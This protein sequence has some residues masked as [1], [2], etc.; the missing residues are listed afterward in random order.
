VEFL[1]GIACEWEIALEATYGWEWLARLLEDERLSGVAP[2]GL[3]VGDDREPLEAQR[4]RLG[5][6]RLPLGH[7]GDDAER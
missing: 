2:G 7:G 5:L 1:R 4:L 6:A 3:A